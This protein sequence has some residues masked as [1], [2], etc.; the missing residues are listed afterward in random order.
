[1]EDERESFL[2]PTYIVQPQPSFGAYGLFVE[3]KDKS[4]SWHLTSKREVSNVGDNS[5]ISRL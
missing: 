3:V 4:V 5:G 2:K 1:M